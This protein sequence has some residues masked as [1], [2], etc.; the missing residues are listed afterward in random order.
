[1]A[2]LVGSV[3]FGLRSY[4]TLIL[5]QS[6]QSLGVADVSSI[7]GWMTLDYLA[8]TYGVDSA[9]IREQLQIPAATG[10]DLPL[11]DIAAQQNT[12]VLDFVQSAQRAVAMLANTRPEP[13][14]DSQSL[15]ESVSERFLAAVLVYGY[16]ALLAAVFLG[17]LG[18]PVPAGLATALA[19][20][21]VSAEH[22]AL[23]PSFLI[24][25]S[26]SI[27]GDG[28]AYGVGRSASQAWLSRWGRW[29][30]YTEQ[31]RKRVATL[32]A[33]GGVATV[34]AG[35]SILSQVS[36]VVGLL[37]G[38]SRYS[39]ERFALGATVGR[40]LW[41]GMYFGL[42]Y[43]AGA[44]FSAASGF[45]YNLGALILSAALAF[46]AARPFVRKLSRG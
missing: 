6:A 9:R 16:P 13:Q 42:G 12:G 31:N 26:G 15:F 20:S 19:G 28:V 24:A 23:L 29:L 35:M 34:I 1:V 45:L 27:I 37:A 33:A 3:H 38:L 32:F 2:G 41:T 5:L 39:V 44:N 8:Q 21:L 10:N 11:R 22:L 14:P 7:R 30:G 18:F 36:S 4:R 46:A 40:F 43:V 17:S 25:M